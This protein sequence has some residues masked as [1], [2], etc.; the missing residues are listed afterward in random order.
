MAKK[1]IKYYYEGKLYKASEWDISNHK[2]KDLVESEP[3]KAELTS[4]DLEHLSNVEA[5]TEDTVSE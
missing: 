2:P 1:T 4:E 5:E 3:K